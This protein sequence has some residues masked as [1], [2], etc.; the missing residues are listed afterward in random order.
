MQDQT[1]KIVLET[2]KNRKIIIQVA[3]FFTLIFALKLTQEPC[4]DLESKLK[5]RADR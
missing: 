3:S 4:E 1:F 2:V 5:G